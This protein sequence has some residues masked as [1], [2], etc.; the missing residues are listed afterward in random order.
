VGNNLWVV[1]LSDPDGYK[2]CFESPTDVP[3]GTK[4]SEWSKS[5]KAN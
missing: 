4:Y 2:V 3:E 1:E 5:I